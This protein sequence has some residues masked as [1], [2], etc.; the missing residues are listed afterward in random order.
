MTISRRARRQ[1]T[2]FLGAYGLY[3]AGRWLAVADLE[4]AREHAH[5]LLRLERSL[6]IGVERSVQDAFGGELVRWVLS[7]VYLGAQLVVVPAALLWLYR[8]APAIYRRLR[9]TVIATWAL[10]VPIHA[11]FP[12]AP[13]RLAG[14]GMTD[15]VSQQAAVGMTGRSTMFYNQFAAMP[16]LH[17]G[18]ACAVALALA[19]AVRRRSARVLALLWGPLVC[20]T[21]VA[22][23]NHYLLD[24]VAG[25]AVSVAGFF[26]RPAAERLWTA[27]RRTSAAARGRRRAAR[28]STTPAGN[29]AA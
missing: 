7:Y 1:L 29:L 20:L 26:A 6:G 3:T 19:F 28:P 5:D 9:D 4:P 14:L 22:T 16:S 25:I 18:F 13:P 11:A 2:V 8:R 17:C 10:A 15:V 12:V 21:V 24:V 27:A 23:A